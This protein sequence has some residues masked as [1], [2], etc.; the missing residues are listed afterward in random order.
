MMVLVNLTFWPM[1]FWLVVFHVYADY[2][3]Q[4]DFLATGKNH[5]TDLGKIFWPYALSA[6]A[7]IH[8]GFVAFATGHISLGLA[9]AVVHGI[10]DRLKCDCKLT[11][12]EDQLVHVV[13]KVVWAVLAVTVLGK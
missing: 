7:L 10:T 8:G 6:H 5:N 11:L 3:G 1:L 4:G 13:C 12:F 2:P 9:E